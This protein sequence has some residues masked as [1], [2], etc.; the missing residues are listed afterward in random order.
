M[1]YVLCR[2]W[3]T[4]FQQGNLFTA[5]MIIISVGAVGGMGVSF[6]RTRRSKIL[7]GQVGL[8]LHDQQPCTDLFSLLYD[9]NECAQPP[10]QHAD[11]PAHILCKTL[12]S[13]LLLCP[14][15]HIYMYPSSLI[16]L[17]IQQMCERVLLKSLVASFTRDPLGR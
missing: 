7:P 8:R 4:I 15:I 6:C 16:S 14:F 5:A 3:E 2:M 13:M 12:I 9:K 11:F 10:D 1:S 17:F